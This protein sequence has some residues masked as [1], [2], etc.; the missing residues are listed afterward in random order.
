M[1]EKFNSLPFGEQI[2]IA[3]AVIGSVVA[4]GWAVYTESSKEPGVSITANNGAIVQTG[5]GNTINQRDPQDKVIIDALLKDKKVTGEHIN[6]LKKT[7]QALRNREDKSGEEALAL[8]AEGK[9]D[10]AEALFQQILVSKKLEGVKSLQ[11]A[12]AAARHIGS[13]T[14]L[15]DTEKALKAYKEATELDPGNPVSWNQLGHLLKRIGDLDG[16]EES[17]RTV[18]TIAKKT[19]DQKWTAIASGNLGILY[20]TR[21]ELE[22]AETMYEQSLAINKALGRKEGMAND[23][24]NLGNLYQTRGELEKAEEMYQQS[25]AINKALGRKEGM[26]NGYGSLGV[27]YKT[28]GELEK[29]EGMYEQSLA[30]NKALGRKEGMANQYGSLG[31]LYQTRGELEKA[32][33]LYKKSLSLFQTIGAQPQIEL[34]QGWLK[35]LSVIQE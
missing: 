33:E 16:A 34:V 29:A 23:Y 7:I 9:V 27:L 30:I 13:L 6:E 11:A 8:L 22:K 3:I 31:N 28:R 25:L 5:S 18:F 17:Y 19:N 15:H 21:G 14:F 20:K 12:A 24:G 1:W 2:T 10:K 4:A 32:E 35:D 26:A